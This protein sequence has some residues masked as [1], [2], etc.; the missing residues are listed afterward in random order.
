MGYCRQEQPLTDPH[1]PSV[2]SAADPKR[3][4]GPVDATCIVVGAIIGVGIFFTPSSV[5]RLAGSGEL[6]LVAWGIGAVI[7][8]L[9]ALTFAELGGMYQRNGGQY[10]M[11]RDAYGPLVAF[12][13]VFCNATAVQAGA[14][15]IIAIICSQNLIV[16]V[17]GIESNAQLELVIAALLVVLLV[18]AN[19][20][21][22]RW[23]SLIQNLTVFAKLATLGVVTAVAVIASPRVPEPAATQ[24]VLGAPGFGLVGLI[25][26][27]LVPA[28]FS[29]GGW[30]H[31]L[32]ITGEVRRPS[33]NVPLALIGGVGVVGAIYFVVNWAYLHLLG[34][35]GVSSSGPVASEAV[36]T[37]WKHGGRIIAGA[38][39]VSAFGVLNAQ[40]L[41]GP[42]LVFGMARDGRFFA[43]FARLSGTKGTPV[44]AIVLLACI[45]MVLL[46]VAGYDFGAVDN[47]LTGVVFVDSFFLGLTGLSLV[48]LR[49]KR[50]DAHRPF[51]VLAYPFVPILFVLSEIGILCGALIVPGKWKV[52]LIGVIWIA[53]AWLCYMVF[54]RN[55]QQPAPVGPSGGA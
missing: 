35:E 28:F 18:A 39:A 33:R 49:F 27:A 40:F 2:E 26:A 20:V 43:P 31:A 55:S 14:I 50:R 15:A 48:V 37:V 46:L 24:A 9:G 10:E 21:G 8:M 5:A 34:Y 41:S 38:V 51:R 54:F 45:A 29:F 22:V 17:T 47:L 7:A 3:V 52:A 1:Q 42:R 25:F 4:L 19:L 30:Q 13:F 12:M 44:A 36:N 23:G 53:A 16:A 6:A 11:L 32:W